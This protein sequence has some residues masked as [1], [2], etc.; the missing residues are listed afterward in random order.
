[1]SHGSARDPE[2]PPRSAVDHPFHMHQNP[3]W[4]MRIEDIDGN[5]LGPK[6]E[7]GASLL[8]RWQDVVAIPRNGG[9]VVFRSRFWDYHGSYVNHCHILQHEDWGMMQTVEIVTDE[10]DANCPLH[11]PDFEYPRP[12]PK[13]MTEFCEVIHTEDGRHYPDCP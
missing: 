7:Q 11:T 12:T 8:P 2:E 5:D 6:D 4:V 10:G 3:F 13:E 1:M 9:R